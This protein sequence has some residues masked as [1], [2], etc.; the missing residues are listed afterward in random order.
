MMKFNASLNYHPLCF[1]KARKEAKRLSML[2]AAEEEEAKA[3]ADAEGTPVGEGD[4]SEPKKEKKVPK[5][6]MY[7]IAGTC[8]HF[9]Q[10]L[11][12]SRI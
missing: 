12:K 8:V 7:R 5:K 11:Y 6:L 3:T 9:F 1:S 4:E 10:N 2:F